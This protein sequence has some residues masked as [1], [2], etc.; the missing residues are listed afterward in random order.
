MWALYQQAIVEPD[1]AARDELVFQILQIHIDEGPFLLG[2]VAD[3]PNI[4]VASND[5]LNVPTRD[6][7]PLGGWLGP[8]VIGMPGAL[9][10]PEVYYFGQ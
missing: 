4:V 10:Y 7:I 6:D 1:V 5:I 8:G 2:A 9:T 3:P